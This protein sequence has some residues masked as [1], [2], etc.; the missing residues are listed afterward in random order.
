MDSKEKELLKEIKELHSQ[1]Q[2]DSQ[3]SLQRAIKL[4]GILQKQKERVGHGNFIKWVNKFLPFSER[5]SRN[6]LSLNQNKEKIKEEKV[7]TLSDAY[8]VIKASKPFALYKNDYERTQKSST[9]YTPP[10]VS[11]YLHSIISPLIKPSVVLDPAIGKGSLTKF[12]QESGAKIIGVDIDTAGKKHCDVF[13][14]SKFE[15]IEEWDYDKPDFIIC[16]P[17]FNGNR[18]ML[19]PELFLRHITELFGEKVKVVL[20]VPMGFRL[21]VKLSSDRWKWLVSSK[22]KITSIISLPIDIFGAKFHAEILCFNI[23]KLRPHYFLY[24]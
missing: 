2:N 6:Y 5:T 17:P 13:I 8:S 20:F 1:I 7:K 12:W 3:K 9:V 22:L 18:P 24:E 19:Y 23:S 16:N 14:S 10:K 15:E 4:G 11:Q 21:N